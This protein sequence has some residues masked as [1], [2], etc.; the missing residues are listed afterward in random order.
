MGP[1]LAEVVA[2][3]HRRPEPRAAGAGEE[4]TG[5]SDGDVVDGPALA[6][7]AADAEVAATGV[8]IEDE[9]TL[10][11]ADKEGQVVGH[12]DLRRFRRCVGT[13]SSVPRTPSSGLAITEEVAP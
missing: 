10:G 2:P 6:Q 3:P 11:G 12:Q 4:L 9:R 7:R 5:P 8:A 1:G 13:P